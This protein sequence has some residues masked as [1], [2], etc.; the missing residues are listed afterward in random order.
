MKEA[1]LEL[2]IRQKSVLTKLGK[3]LVQHRELGWP[4]RNR[5]QY[6]R[7]WEGVQKPAG[8]PRSRQLG[9]EK[10]KPSPSGTSVTRQRVRDAGS[11]A[12]NWQNQRR[13]AK[14][15]RTRV[16]SSE[17][18]GRRSAA[19]RQAELKPGGR[20]GRLTEQE[21]RTKGDATGL[22]R[23]GSRCDLTAGPK[24][25]LH[26]GMMTGRHGSGQSVP[27]GGEVDGHTAVWMY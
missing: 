14:G 3:A 19:G 10:W 11:Q 25:R 4:G 22:G 26:W 16:W 9:N 21:L 6:R 27:A 5:G 2:E 12:G 23:R 20:T 18:G 15:P 7:R 1:S 8:G 13:S 24:R 17:A